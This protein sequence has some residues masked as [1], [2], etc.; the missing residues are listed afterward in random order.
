MS[1]KH[2]PAGYFNAG[3]KLWFWC[4]VALLGLLMSVTGLLMDFV[5]FGQ[6]R[7]LLQLADYLHIAGATLYIVAAM[8]HIYI[9]TIGTPGAYEAMRHGTVDEEW[10]KAHHELWYEEIKAG[11]TPPSNTPPPRGAQQRPG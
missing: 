8:G 7:Y 9:G 6:T 2:I 11:G 4:G 1:H 10:A 5:N 3:E